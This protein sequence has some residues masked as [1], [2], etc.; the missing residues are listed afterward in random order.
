LW[1]ALVVEGGMPSASFAGHAVTHVENMP[2]QQRRGH[3]TL[4]TNM[5]AAIRALAAACGRDE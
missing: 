4:G 2:T 3:A 5:I 1:R